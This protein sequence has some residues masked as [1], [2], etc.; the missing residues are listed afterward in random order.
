MRLCLARR[1]V[2]RPRAAL[3]PVHPSTPALREQWPLSRDLLKWTDQRLDHL[4]H[5]AQFPAFTLSYDAN[6]RPRLSVMMANGSPVLA[7][8]RERLGL[9]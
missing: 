4:V 7:V 3:P 2:G 1:A 9:R 6:V 5:R 8:S